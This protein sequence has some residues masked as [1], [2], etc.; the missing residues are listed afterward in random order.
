MV[1][2][3]DEVDKGPVLLRLSRNKAARA[4]LAAAAQA[5]K[6]QE[7]ELQRI[8]QLV[9]GGAI[10]GSELDGAR[11]AHENARA[12]YAKAMESTEDYSLTAPWNGIVAKVYVTEGDYVAP[13]TPLIEIFD[14]ASLVVRSAIPETISTEV[15]EDM[16]VEVQLDAYPG[17]LFQGTL[18]RIFPQLD[19]H[20]HTRTVEVTLIDPV[21][22]IPGM[23]AR[24]EVVLA[25]IS[26]AI[27]VPDNCLVATP[28]GGFTAFVVEDGK[29]VRRKLDTGMEI[30]GRVQILSGLR[31]GD[32]LVVAGLEKLKDGAVVK[33]LEPT[34]L[35]PE[36]AES[37]GRS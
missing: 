3:G 19:E 10:P 20:T 8:A 24:I 34:P 22:L 2:A 21:D 9:Q 16:P 28:E 17:T 13:R 30:N 36:A 31:T 27:T 32:R 7:T 14:P 5:L 26:D 11:S 4:Q 18:S 1:R 15:R 35:S 6:E 12:Q 37:A 33:V 29:A 23:F 25:R